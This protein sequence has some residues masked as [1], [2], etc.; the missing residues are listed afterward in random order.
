MPYWCGVAAFNVLSFTLMAVAAL[1]FLLLG[2][3]L[4]ATYFDWALAD[5]L[6]D[7]VVLSLNALWI[8]GSVVNVTGGLAL[9]AVG[10][11]LPAHSPTLTHWLIGPLLIAPFGLWRIWRGYS[12]FPREG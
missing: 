5:R 7:A 3:L 2:A 9:V 12:A 1:P 10:L 11:W 4:L 6:L 8:A